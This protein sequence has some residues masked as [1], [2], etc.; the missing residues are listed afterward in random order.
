MHKKKKIAVVDDHNLLRKALTQY[1]NG[2]SVDF[3]VSIEAANGQE[4]TEILKRT[5]VDDRP[6]IV[7]MDYN[8]PLM[9][10]CMTTLWIKDNMP[11]IKVLIL[12]TRSDD[13]TII[14]LFKAGV[15]GYLFKNID[16][17]ELFAAL[18]TI[19]RGE[20]YIKLLDPTMVPDIFGQSPTIDKWYT[21]T[22]IWRGL[23]ERERNFAKLCA[24]DAPDIEIFQKMGFR[25]R[26]VDVD[27]FVNQLYAKFGVRTRVG[28]VL[29]LIRFNLLNLNE[30]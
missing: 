18:E 12:T 6:K 1:I 8:M 21:L 27:I 7:V 19:D 28:L 29:L 26:A 10:G 14:R 23:S 13:L 30:L 16:G 25:I 4:F 2:S 5:S 22:N 9:D 17:D 3:T 11:E 20:P 24:S 15:S